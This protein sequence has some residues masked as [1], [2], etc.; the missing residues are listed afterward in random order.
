MEYRKAMHASTS[1]MGMRDG[2][3]FTCTH[4]LTDNE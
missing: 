2:V 4:R 3:I 1:I